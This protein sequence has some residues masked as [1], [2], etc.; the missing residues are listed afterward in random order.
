MT[1]AVFTV[2]EGRIVRIVSKG[3]TGYAEAGEDIVCAAV[4]AVLQGAVLGILEVAKAKAE[5]RTD[6]DKGELHFALCEGQDEQVMHDAEV[7]LRTA[8][9]SLQDIAASYSQ[10]VKVEVK[11]L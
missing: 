11:G 1:K 4:S 7:I 6:D 3:H 2:R 9:K 8:L 10:F 5:Y